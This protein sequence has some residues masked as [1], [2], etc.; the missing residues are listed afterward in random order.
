MNEEAIARMKRREMDEQLKKLKKSLREMPE[1]GWIHAVRLA[2]GMTTRQLG[3]RMGNSGHHVADIER[4]EKSGTIRVKKLH[5]IAKAMEC[6][7]V[8]AF[9]PVSSLEEIYQDRKMEK[10]RR[11]LEPV[12]GKRRAKSGAM[13]SVVKSLADSI[14]PHEVWDD[15]PTFDSLIAEAA[16][17]AECGGESRKA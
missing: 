1:G 2:L 4:A 5:E 7:F 12:M 3:K 10:A 13:R 17:M 6:R 9:V 8:Y 16:K 15:A 14:P 11:Q